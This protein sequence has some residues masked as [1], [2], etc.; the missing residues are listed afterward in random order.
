MAELGASDLVFYPNDHAILSTRIEPYAERLGTKGA[1]LAGLPPAWTPEYAILTVEWVEQLA[2]GDP[3]RLELPPT[4]VGQPLIL[5]SS[6]VGETI[7][8]RG[9]YLSVPLEQP[10]SDLDVTSTVLRIREDALQKRPDVKVAIIIQRFLPHCEKGTLGNLNSL[11]KTR[12][13]WSRFSEI[14]GRKTAPER[15]NSQRDA[16]ADTRA[17]LRVYPALHIDR[18]FGSAVRWLIDHLGVALGRDRMLL[19]WA[20]AEDKVFLLQCDLD[21]DNAVGVN[22]MDQQITS[23]LSSSAGTATYFRAPDRSDIDAWDKLKIIDELS[24]DFA[25]L[26]QALYVLTYHDAAQALADPAK[27][28][29]LAE[30]YSAHFGNGGI[31]RVS[32]RTGSSSTTNLPCNSSCMAAPAAIAWIRQALADVAERPEEASERAFILHKFIGAR[33]GAWALYDPESPY[34]QVHANWGLPDSLQYYPYDAWDVHT[35]TEE[36]NAYPSYKSHFLWPQP[37]GQ[38]AFEEI[39]NSIARHQCL[40]SHEVLD[41]ARRTNAIGVK[42]G[43]R[44]AVMWF[45]GV[46]SETGATFSLPWYRTFEYSEPDLDTALEKDHVIIDV[47]EPRDLDEVRQAFAQHT[48]ALRVAMDI[49]PSEHLIRE[50]HF[51]EQIIEVAQAVDASVIFSGS[52]LSHPFF[53]LKGRVRVYLRVQRKSFRTRSRIKYHK[54]VRD[55]IPERVSAKHERVVY[56]NLGSREILQLLTG[57]LIEEA[58]ELIAAE[59]ADAT[60][61]EL[62]DVY[63]VLRGMMHQAGVEEQRVVEIANSKRER[64]GGF[65]KGIF[66][67]ETSLPKPGEPVVDVRNVSFDELVREE[68]AK[69]RVRIPFALLGR[70]NIAGDRVFKIPGTD[71]AVRFSGGRD[72]FEISLEQQEYQLEIDFD[73]ED[74]LLD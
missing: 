33:S 55:R 72:G 40:K 45:A 30:E 42:L 3:P 68:Y 60:A 10:C 19:E 70:L 32:R 24:T 50:P 22:P 21:Q 41:I 12:E 4:L 64:V 67:L 58:Q 69:E 49:Q 43:R 52:P 7:W 11:S 35:I 74:D 27:A 20:T 73:G 25:P 9:T 16:P 28:A 8:E 17:P 15:F 14:A 62:A 2:Q 39:R 34:I 57:K 44:V 1:F 13:Q 47:R 59:G 37:G 54:L 26:P 5:R 31:I 53:Q 36:V 66:L 6:I 63:E 18:T 71:K 65:D 48:P 29:A 46:E 23:R 51:L 61:E 56:A 38:W